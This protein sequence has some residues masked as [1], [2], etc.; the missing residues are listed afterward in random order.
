MTLISTLR[1]LADQG[2]TIIAVIHQPS[3]HVFSKFDDLLLVSE[4]KQMYYGPQQDVRQYME[5]LG[6]PA[7]DE[8]GTAEHVLDCISRT[9]IE[10][11]TKE[12]ADDRFEKIAQAAAN[13]KVDLGIE[14]TKSKSMEHVST[15]V[16]KSG[17]KSGLL[18]QFRLLFKRSFREITRGKTAIIVK[19]VQQV[20]LGLIYGGI[21]G[22]GNN[23]ASIQ[24]RFGLMSL[25]AIGSA[26]MAVAASIRS[27]PKEKA[28]VEGELAAKM[29][30]TLPYFVGKA[31]SELPLVGVFNTIFGTILYRLAGL[32][33]MTGKFARFIGLL[34]THGLACE[35]T[36]LLIG[37]I[38][39]N[40]DVALS[41]FPAIIVLNIIFD[42]K[43]ISEE[44]TPRLLR[45][46]PKV[47]LIRWGFEGLCVNEFEGLTFDASGPRRGPVAKTGEDALARFGL[48]GK[49]VGDV[50]KAQGLITLFCWVFSYVGLSVTRQKF[51]TMETPKAT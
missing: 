1:K 34:S 37:A 25:I 16:R 22:L 9:P 5:D 3:Q 49:T 14:Q 7:L 39:P 44:N 2:K 19:I 11:E 20:S 15:V 36:G 6:F 35:V 43:N 51:L 42:G 31:L 41:I 10:D 23:Q 50:I 27:F 30:N 18:T 46:I 48:G 17:P 47:G 28:I 29:Y 40:S 32:S 8:I 26:N 4:G 12:E 21:Y 24:D 33:R 38:S 13:V 45:W